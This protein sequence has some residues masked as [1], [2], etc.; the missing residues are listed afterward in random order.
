MKVLIVDDHPVV[1]AGL[2]RLLAA[3]PQSEIR[4]ARTG[5][6]AL[7]VFRDHRP[8][9]VILDLNL[10]GSSGLELIGRFKTEDAKA[11]ILVLTMHDNPV[12]VR[13]A[14]QAGAAGYVSK[15]ASAEELLE[16]IKRVSG[17]HSY[18]EREI[19]QELALWNSRGPAHP[20]MDLSAR[21]LE[22]LRLLGEGRSLAE[23]AGTVGVGYKTVAN[24]CTQ[25]KAKL[26]VARTAELIR[27]AVSLGIST[28]D[29][30]LAAESN[31]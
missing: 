6:E 20:L 29:A 26:G 3:E 23:I 18:I 5:Q 4:E 22:I 11:Q 28:G 31:D 9:L 27:V 16:A 1:R 24:H 21:D 10:P 7:A 13:R 14:L 25:L 8:G 15:N 19:A 2:R 12:Y 17:G 30:P